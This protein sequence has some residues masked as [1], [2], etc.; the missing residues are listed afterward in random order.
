VQ[1]ARPGRLQGP[2]VISNLY[3]DPYDPNFP[4]GRNSPVWEFT[5]NVTKVHGNHTFKAGFSLR[6]TT[7]WGYNEAGN[8]G[9][10][11]QN[12]TTA[13]NLGNTV[14]TTI[15]PTGS[16]ISSAMRQTFDS[17][18]NDVLGRMNQVVQSYFSNLETWQPAGTPRV[19]NFDVQEQGYFFQDDWKIRRNFSLNLGIRWEYSGV[20]SERDNQ[21]GTLDQISSI[22]TV[23]Q[24]SNMTVQKSG[25]WYNKDWNNFAPRVGFS[26]D[27]KGDGKTAVR[28]AAGVYY[29][30]LIG[31][32]ISAVDSGTPGF[33]QDVFVYPNQNGTDVRVNDGIPT[34][35]AP[36]APQ[37]TLPV[38]RGTSISVFNPY[39]RNPYV[40]QY[41]LNVQ[42]EIMRNTVLEVGYVG[43]HG[44]KL[45]MAYNPNQQRIYGDFLKN[46]KEL[47][48]YQVNSSAPI[49][50]DNTLVRIFGTPASAISSLGASNFSQAQV[51]SAAT[52]LDRNFYTRYAAAGVS[53]YYVRN[54]PQYINVLQGTNAGRSYYDSLQVSVRRTMGALKLNANYTFAKSIDNGSVE[55]NGFANPIDSFNLAL[56]RGR[57]D[58]DR[59]HSFNMSASYILPVGK[60][61]KFGGSMPQWAD[62]LIG[63][64]ELGTLMIWQ[65]GGTFT[66]SSGRN[67]TFGAVNTWAN[68]SGDRNLGGIE[69]KG[70][71]VWYFPQD[72]TVANFSFPLA[73][74]FGNTGRNSFRGPRYFDVDMSIVK[75][76]KI[77]ETHTITFRAEGYNLFNNANFANPGVSLTTPATFGKVSAI[78]GQPRIFQMALRYDF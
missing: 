9:G 51:G 48:A 13:A 41:S 50:P 75:R 56:N 58:F 45:F 62:S 67:T 19:R 28:G 26:W 42:R 53:P 57:S 11:Y 20:P 40:F 7:Q 22:N 1:F 3:T 77:W 18:Y 63:G 6:F 14:P 34:T 44:I 2:T 8:S 33:G 36:A 12:V 55:G 4:Q 15:G 59:P 73:G 72:T 5:D 27:V 60:G 52:S 38:T 30:R 71:G 23:S 24:I 25:Q 61:R 37:L 43:S 35:P 39:L 64:W 78:V 54:Y 47:Q 29:D 17:L 16:S 32:T 70:N 66:I 65:S 69:R 46:F 49:S 68:Y 74:E 21:M 10:I 76:F 31:A